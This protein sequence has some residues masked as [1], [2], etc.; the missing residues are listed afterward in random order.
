MSKPCA[1]G[2]TESH[3]DV[4]DCAAALLRDRGALQDVL[5][6]M[7]ERHGSLAARV[8]LTVTESGRLLLYLTTNRSASD[9]TM[10]ALIVSQLQAAQTFGLLTLEKRDA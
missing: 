7:G 10:A 8:E 1:C 6:Q 9:G 4:A 3:A 2:A 5:D